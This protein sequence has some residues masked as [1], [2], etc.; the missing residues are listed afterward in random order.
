[1]DLL[2]EST[3]V[4]GDTCKAAVNVVDNIDTDQSDC[5]MHVANL[6]LG[7]GFGTK[8][9][10]RTKQEADKTWQMKNVTTIITPGGVF[11]DQEQIVKASRKVINFF[12]KFPQH[13]DK[14]D[15]VRKAMDMC[16]SLYIECEP[17]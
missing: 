8:E 10:T 6:A 15:H 5:E 4:A 16:K 12:S 17:A 13:K 11:P 1:M 14:R 9:N 7:Y 3:Y 2:N